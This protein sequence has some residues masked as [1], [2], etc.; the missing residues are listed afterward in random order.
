MV[1]HLCIGVWWKLV[2]LWIPLTRIPYLSYDGL[3]R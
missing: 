2:A 3:E 1:V